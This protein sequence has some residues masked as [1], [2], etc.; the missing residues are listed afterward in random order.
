[1]EPFNAEVLAQTN[2]E[3]TEHDWNDIK[4]KRDVRA[5]DSR[6]GETDVE[7]LGDLNR[8]EEGEIFPDGEVDLEKLTIKPTM[9]ER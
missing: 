8:D 2:Y 5:K 1:M 3:L 6:E 7:K 4:Y 9:F